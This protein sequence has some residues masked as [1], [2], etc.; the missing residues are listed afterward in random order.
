MV[1]DFK[2]VFVSHRYSQI[3]WYRNVLCDLKICVQGEN[4]LLFSH[5]NGYWKSKTNL[6]YEDVCIIP[7]SHLMT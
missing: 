2:S 3:T 5:L 7:I 1:K 4:A 6:F